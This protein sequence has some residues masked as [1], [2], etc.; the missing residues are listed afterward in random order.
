MLAG[1]LVFV[2]LGIVFLVA[3]STVTMTV[4]GALVVPFFGFCSV[5]I[6]QRLLRHGRPELVLDD[7]GVDHA[8]LGR[9]GWD[10]IAA[11]RIREQ[12]VRNTSQRFIELVLHDP[13]AY[14]AR[15]PKLVRS[16]ASMNARLGF[17]PA[18]MTTNTLPVPPEAILDAMRRH[19]PALVVEH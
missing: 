14:L 13:D 6:V 12:R 11:V 5:S 17:G 10:E 3:H 4:A 18:N 2:A 9:F 8:R 1:S 15:A 7:A 16:T 19:H